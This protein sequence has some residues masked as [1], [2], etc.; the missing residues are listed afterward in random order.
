[1]LGATKALNALG[2][3]APAGR[4]AAAGLARLAD[5]EPDREVGQRLRLVACGCF[6]GAVGRHLVSDLARAPPP[7]CANASLCRHTPI[8]PLKSARG[9]PLR[10]TRLLG[11]S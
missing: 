4:R 5:L 11:S 10:I 6:G 8:S 3:G 2:G 7:W 1:M 9:M